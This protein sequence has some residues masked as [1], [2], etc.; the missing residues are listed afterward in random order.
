M[1]GLSSRFW[2]L[3]SGHLVNRLGG[4]VFT[5]LSLYLT[6]VHRYSVQQAGLVVSAYGAGTLV[7][8]PLGGLLADK[9]GRRR[10]I[11]LGTGS[12]SVLLVL[13]G[14]AR[15]PWL[16]LAAAFFSGLCVDSYR[17]AIFA[18]VSDLVPE[19]DRQRAFGYMYWAS[20]VSFAVASSIAGWVASAGFFFLFLGD[21]AS[22]ALF[23][24]MVW[25][26]FTETKP[27]A[28]PAPEPT[29]EA[30]SPAAPRAVR[31]WLPWTDLRFVA[32]AIPQGLV[33]LVFSQGQVALPLS[34][35]A[36]GISTAQY[37]SVIALNGV[38]IVVLQPFIVRRLETQPAG[39]VLAGAAVLIGGGYA[40]NMF[41]AT[42]LQYALCVVVWTLGEIAMSASAPNVVAQLA[43]ANARGVYNGAMF[44]TWSFGFVTAPLIGTAVLARFSTGVLWGAC[45][46]VCALAA[47]SH[48]LL[49]DRVTRRDALRVAG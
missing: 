19:R 11:L 22:T 42:A 26:A 46:V 25:Y 37:G 49:T 48:V 31:W 28:E 18:A 40:A 1:L 2:L 9:L 13:F 7:A 24:A 38:L 6:E 8:A 32:F 34:M 14:L 44:S 47:L 12:A 10:A 27:S 43:P 15:G 29:P 41:A 17:P 4:F 3:F 16:M 23:A 35:R 45:G 20:N 36:L 30:L 21:A 33:Q 5:F 39:R